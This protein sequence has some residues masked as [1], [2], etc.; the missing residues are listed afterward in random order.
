MFEAYDSAQLI[1]PA[2]AANRS[3]IA[4]QAL[5]LM[6]N[7]FVFVQAQYFAERLRKRAGRC[8]RRSIGVPPALGF[9]QNE[10]PA[11]PN[12]S[13]GPDRPPNCARRFQPTNLL[14]TMRSFVVRVGTPR[15]WRGSPAWRLR[16]AVRRGEM[17]LAA[18]P[19]I[20][21][22]EG[23]YLHLLLRRR[24]PGRYV[25]S[26][27]ELLSARRKDDRRRQR[28]ARW[29]RPA[30][31]AIA[32]TLRSTPCGMDISDLSRTSPSRRRSRAHIRSMQCIT[33]RRPACSDEHRH[34]ARR[35]ALRR[36][37]VT[38]GWH[39]E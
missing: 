2:T 14:S 12:I 37:L 35:S 13:G 25:R 10:T 4:P 33:R 15:T 24:K 38:Y 20:R 21:A 17:P 9:A 8:A 27:A 19:R 11:P 5:L 36:L 22:N 18:K 1:T 32:V 23:R 39:G 16:T 29:A 26:Q 30:A 7:N 34:G 31:H 3:T 28:V 6:N